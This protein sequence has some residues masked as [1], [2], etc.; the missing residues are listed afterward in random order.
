MANNLSEAIQLI[1]GSSPNKTERKLGN[2]TYGRINSDGS[3]S[4][5]M[6]ST[7][8]D[9]VTFNTD[10][11]VTLDTGGWLINM[12]YSATTKQRMNKYLPYGYH[13]F[14]HNHEWYISLGRDFVEF[15]MVHDGALGS[16]K[17]YT[18]INL[19]NNSIR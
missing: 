12:T 14:K 2:N 19:D 9:I 4:I 11:T 10:N 13:V 18:T 3:V 5:R 16:F 17:Y 6:H 1:K 8:T 7:D 15:P